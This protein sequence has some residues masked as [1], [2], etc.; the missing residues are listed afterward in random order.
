M[1]GSLRRLLF[2]RIVD[3]GEEG[4]RDAVLF[5]WRRDSLRRANMFRVVRLNAVCQEIWDFL[6]TDTVASPI[7]LT[8]NWH[9]SASVKG[10]G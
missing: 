1:T 4:G 9:T 2:R 7:Q 5:F 3:D 8:A 6:E 10:S